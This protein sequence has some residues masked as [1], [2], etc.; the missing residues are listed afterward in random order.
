MPSLPEW[1]AQ[2]DYGGGWQVEQVFLVLFAWFVASFLLARFF[3]RW[4]R[5]Q[6]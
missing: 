6:A 2:D 1:V 3:F 5:E 4:N